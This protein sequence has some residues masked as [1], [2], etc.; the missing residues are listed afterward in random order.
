VDV[1][2]VP[3]FQDGR[4][5]TV[6]VLL[7]ASTQLS[8]RPADDGPDLELGAGEAALVDALAA[9]AVAYTEA[10][11]GDLSTSFIDFD[12]YDSDAHPDPEP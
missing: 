8:V 6:R 11:E 10:D 2:T 12:L 9:G 1:V 5:A 4:P 3:F 7:N